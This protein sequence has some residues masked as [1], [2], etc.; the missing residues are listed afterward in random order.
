[1]TDEQKPVAWMDDFGN[2]FPLGANKGAA[3]W[4]DAHKRNWK[5]LYLA[6]PPAQRLTDAEFEVH[7]DG[8][9]YA[10]AS[11]PRDI[12]LREARYYASQCTG[13][14]VIY[15]VTRTVVEEIAQKD[16]P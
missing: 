8:D 2:V 9:Y 7:E 13:A 15:E 5:P 14:V 10:S 1:M 3:S 12:A 4:I 16:T 6:A 11:G